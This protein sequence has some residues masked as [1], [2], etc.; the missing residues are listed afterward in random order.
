MAIPAYMTINS[1]T[2]GE[3]SKDASSADSVGKDHQESR[4]DQIMV[5]AFEHTAHVPCDVIS[6]QTTGQRIHGPVRITKQFDRSSPL[7]LQALT[8]GSLLDKVEISWYRTAM[9][10]GQEHY[11]STVLEGARV[12]RV[13]DVMHNAQNPETAHLTHLEEVDFCYDT[14]SWTHLASNTSHE[15]TLRKLEA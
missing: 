12:V 2:L 7:L 3:I 4:K 1:G 6:G 5:L 10:G 11:Y 8:S 14:I 13:R 15:D 9:E